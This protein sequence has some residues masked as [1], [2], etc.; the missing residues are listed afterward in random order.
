MLSTDL[1]RPQS[2]RPASAS[3]KSA[4]AS[5]VEFGRDRTAALGRRVSE[6]TPQL[7]GRIGDKRAALALGQNRFVRAI[8]RLA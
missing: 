6:G 2:V 1:K 8:T 3:L 4:G 7:R 5:A